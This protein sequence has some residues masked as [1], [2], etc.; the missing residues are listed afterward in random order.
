MFRI[1]NTIQGSRFL[2][3][4]R[5]LQRDRASGKPDRVHVRWHGAQQ[6]GQTILQPFRVWKQP[7]Y[8]PHKDHL[9]FEKINMSGLSVNILLKIRK[10]ILKVK[11]I[12]QNL[13]DL[14]KI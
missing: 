14:F 4:W 1:F 6:D 3:S 13:K 5:L 7:S 9:K 12:I 8:S 2:Q 10:K 11:K